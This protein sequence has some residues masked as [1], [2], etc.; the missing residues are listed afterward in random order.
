MTILVTGRSGHLGEALT[1]VLRERGQGACGL[2]I[3]PSPYT[4]ETTIFSTI[5]RV[6]D[7]RRASDALGWEPRYDF[8]HVLDCLE[9][10]CDFRSSLA[11]AVGAKG[12]HDEV[13]TDGP[14]PI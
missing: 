14:Y 8:R 4:V 3:K 13:F 11:L 2:D 5:G 9:E 6:C 7:N 1:R 12:Y 10:G